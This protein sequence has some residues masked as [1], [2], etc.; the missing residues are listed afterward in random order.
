MENTASKKT[1]QSNIRV[2]WGLLCS[3]SS[4]DQQRNNISLINVITQVNIPAAD[5][6][7]AESSGHKGLMLQLNHELVIMFRRMGLQSLGADDLNT[8]I[9]ISL[10][11]PKGEV[12]GEILNTI[13]FPGTSRNHGHRISLNSFTVTSEGDYEY[14]VSI[15]NKDN[16]EFEQLYVIPFTVEKI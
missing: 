7:R 10:F 8:D 1:M 16:N 9:K 12:L 13:T 15:F 5:F 2:M 6:V 11:N 3:M 4:I 14:R